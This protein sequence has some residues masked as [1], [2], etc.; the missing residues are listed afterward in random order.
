MVV[1]RPEPTQ[2]A[3]N[4]ACSAEKRSNHEVEDG[5]P[6]RLLAHGLSLRSGRLQAVVKTSHGLRVPGELAMQMEERRNPAR[7]RFTPL[8]LLATHLRFLAARDRFH[9]RR[10]ENESGLRED[11][12]GG[13][14][15]SGVRVRLSVG[16]VAAF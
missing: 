6:G 15:R 11:V 8:L 7:F 4:A 1:L 9:H 3:C 13:D 2:P 12:V 5:E 16:L 14:E 10:P